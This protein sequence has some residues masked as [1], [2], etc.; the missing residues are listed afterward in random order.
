MNELS[1]FY[2]KLTEMAFP[3]SDIESDQ[4][5]EFYSELVEADAYYA[6]KVNTILYSLTQE[7]N[8]DFSYLKLL[9]NQ[10][11]SIDINRLSDVDKIGFKAC[12]NY[13]SFLEQ[14][15]IILHK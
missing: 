5:A 4:L 2:E 12:N 9:R 7:S 13:L 11:D 1:K 8:L 10:L 3:S 15:P 14:L 6:G